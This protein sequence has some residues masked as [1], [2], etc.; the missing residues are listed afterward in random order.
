MGDGHSWRE[1]QNRQ[2]ET[3][4]IEMEKRV[5]FKDVGRA[6]SLTDYLE[7]RLQRAQADKGRNGDACMLQ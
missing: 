1:E 2:K 4:L 6:Q 3:N 5:K 7:T